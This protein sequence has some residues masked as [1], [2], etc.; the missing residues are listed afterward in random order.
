[1]G[2]IW[3]FVLH[4]R[5]DRAFRSVFRFVSDNISDNFCIVRTQT[6]FLM[7]KR[8]ALG[9]FQIIF[10]IIFASFVPDLSMYRLCDSYVLKWFLEILSGMMNREYQL[11]AGT[12]IPAGTRVPVFLAW[13]L[14]VKRVGPVRVLD[15]PGT[16]VLDNQGPPSTDVSRSLPLQS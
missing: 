13:T 12:R 7:E 3:L 15:P 4:T 10:R 16:R 8:K 1:M 11:P 9:A 6:A 2:C 14:P 5:F